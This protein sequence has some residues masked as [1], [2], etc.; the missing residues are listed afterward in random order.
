MTPTQFPKLDKSA[1]KLM[2]KAR[3][4]RVEFSKTS[5]EIDATGRAPLEN[6]DLIHKAGFY[7]LRVPVEYGGIAP[8]VPSD[9]EALSVILTEF[10]AGESST[11]H[12]WQVQMLSRSLFYQVEMPDAT[13]RMLAREILDEGVRFCFPTAESGRVRFE[14]STFCR[15]VPG[16]VLLT[17]N[18]KYGT[19]SVGAR[20]AI[21]TARYEEDG[22][23]IPGVHFLMVRL[24][25]DG[26]TL[27]NDWD[28]MGQRATGT[29]SVDYEEVFVPDGLHWHGASNSANNVAENRLSG[30][31][32]QISFA[33]TILGSGF[34]GLDS[35]KTLLSTEVRPVDG[36][37]SP[38]KDP[39][40]Q[41]DVGRYSAQLAAAQALVIQAARTVAQYALDDR[42]R[43]SASIMVMQA[44]IVVQEAVLDVCDDMFRNLGA[45]SGRRT[46]GIDRFWRN[47]RSLTMHDPINKK[48]RHIG[49]WVLEGTSPPL[50]SIT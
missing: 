8:D 41:Y 14:M 19:G 27:H 3:E 39:C 46:L 42:D 45:S 5:A 30:L 10:A 36:W 37:P 17:G 38:V 26:V 18:K 50:S 49:E 48:Y 34:G 28:N 22:A 7:P 43:P 4:L 16:G 29:N 20:Y 21:A 9:M 33:S 44:K 6:L 31:F 47:A 23:S 32:N 40:I 12:I 2:E 25:A 11:A 35:L 24:D 1:L 15:K 13:K